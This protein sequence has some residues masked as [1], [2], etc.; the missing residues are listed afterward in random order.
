MLYFFFS[1]FQIW[2]WM[3][4]KLRRCDSDSEP[5]LQSVE[6]LW[7]NHHYTCVIR[8]GQYI[9]GQKY[10]VL[11][12]W[13]WYTCTRMS[14][15]SI[16]WYSFIFGIFTV[17]DQKRKNI[18]FYNLQFINDVPCCATS[19]VEVT[20]N[21]VVVLVKFAH[22]VSFFLPSSCN[23]FPFRSKVLFWCCHSFSLSLLPFCTTV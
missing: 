16:I 22:S 2:C 19:L 5:G 13:M 12:V 20:E 8:E 4:W 14:V 9:C 11:L 1:A 15:I 10:S 18:C 21:D 6:C 3:F 23:M 17:R 7:L